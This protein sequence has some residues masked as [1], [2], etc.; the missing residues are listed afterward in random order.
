[1]KGV[2]PLYD[3]LH[4]LS[5]ATTSRGRSHRLA[6]L[7]RLLRAHGA[8]RQLIVTTNFDQALERAF[9]RRARS[10]TSSRTS[11]SGAH[12]GKFLHVARRTASPVSSV[13]NTYAE[14]APER[15]T[16][17]LKIHGGVDPRPGASGR[18]SSS[19][20]TTTSTTSAQADLASVV[21]SAS[22]PGCAAATSCSSATR[23][24][25][26]PACRSSTALWGDERARLPLVGGRARRRRRSSASPGGAGGRRLR[27]PA[28]GLRRPQLGGESPPRRPDAAHERDAVRSAR[29]RASP[30]RGHGADAL[31]FFG[32]ERDREIVVANLV[33]S[34][35]T[36]LYGASGVGKSS[37]LRAGSRTTSVARRSGRSVVVFDAWQATRSRRSARDAA[38]AVGDRAG[39]E[40]LADTLDAC[41]GA[42]GGDVYVAA[43]PGR[44]V[45]PLPRRRA[46]RHVA[47]ALPELVEPA[48]L[49]A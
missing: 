15:R 21:P 39:G 9:R 6:A 19:A 5:P 20:R 23:S 37:L 46:G 28:R 10:S 13:P 27:R 33:A 36:V 11:R 44:R 42:V 40:P 12:R 49:C 31:L 7:P 2:G 16:V 47:E 43:R 24:R 29:T 41:G 30:V 25:V 34:R 45:L 22:P 14:L 1:M 18:A 17:I 8:P 38:T 26:E 4:A 32:R 3:E 35:L 48:R